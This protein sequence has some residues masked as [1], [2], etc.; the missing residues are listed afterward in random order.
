MNLAFA[1][2]FLWIG[3]ELIWLSTRNLEAATPWGVYQTVLTRA[4]GGS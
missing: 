3:A 1:I 4:A 2:V